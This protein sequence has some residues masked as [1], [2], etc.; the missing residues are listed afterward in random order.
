MK[1]L[2]FVVFSLFLYSS[3]YG[4][5]IMRKPT[6]KPRQVEQE[7]IS[8]YSKKNPWIAASQIFGLNVGLWAFDR[9]ALNADYARID[10]KSFKQN[11]TEGFYWDNDR[12][13]TNMFLHPYHGS[14]YYNSARSQGFNFWTSGV[15]A[16]GG[17]AMWEL[18]MENEHPSK[19]D[20]VATPIGGMALGEVLF[21]AS[22]LILDDSKRG[23]N[24][25]RREI[26]AFLVSPTRGLTRLINGDAFRKR[27]TSGRQF[28]L[29]EISIEASV[30]N[31]VVELRNE[32]L[33]KGTGFA[34]DFNI[35]YGDR[36]SVDNPKPFDY[37]TINGNFN[38]QKSQPLLGKLSV[39]GRLWGGELVDN[40][41]DF[42]NIGVYQHFD[43]YDSDTISSVS[44][45]TPYRMA[46]PAAFGIGLMHK[47]KR[48]E[49]WH[50]TSR[51]HLNGILLGASLSDH[52]RV[53]ERNYNLGSGY[54]WKT[55]SQISYKDV[56]GLSLLYEGYRLFS[57]KGYAQSTDFSKVDQNEINAQGDK[58][59]AI[60]QVITPK[61]Q[62]KLK[63]RLYMT[64]SNSLYT[65]RT[66]YKHFP[67]IS[68]TT[69]EGKI[70][71]T[72][73]F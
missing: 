28:G 10:I 68:S 31:R 57:W 4:Q 19:N 66:H 27:P 36:F 33:D 46:I 43:F 71:L 39:M 21:R 13:G 54:G 11:L 63:D 45:E 26:L 70:M 69:G 73:K 3:V 34:V 61:V 60:F 8:Y 59:R 14:L 53:S 65:R 7:D 56:V 2:A 55:E 12:I 16:L 51:I 72:Y 20:I 30:G 64:L 67:D 37:F 32:I 15:F 35:E 44:H 52:Y 38:L 6:T 47:S 50:F 24:R 22:D 25:T 48:F 18:F 23:G 42:V 29:P 58:S 40:D 17:S 5:F 1:K 9:Y 41:K 49:D 62:F